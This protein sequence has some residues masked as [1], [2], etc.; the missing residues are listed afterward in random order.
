M[1]AQGVVGYADDR[2]ADGDGWHTFD[3]GR[4]TCP[5]VVLHGTSDTFVP[6]THARYT[7]RIV[8]GASLD[9]REGL[10]H[11]SILPE[12]VPV[13]GKLLERERRVA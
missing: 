12:M 1:F 8:P 4:I 5:V 2:L 3:V 7:Q 6:A 13:L 10:G 9:V 11:F